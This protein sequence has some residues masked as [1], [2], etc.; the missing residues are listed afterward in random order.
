MLRIRFENWTSFRFYSRADILTMTLSL[1]R[2]SG[3]SFAEIYKTDL[4]TVLGLFF[5]LQNQIKKEE[6]ERKKQEK[7]QKAAQPKHKMPKRP[8]Y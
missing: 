4:G 1:S 2:H 7:E 3:N 8:R 5:E 6:A